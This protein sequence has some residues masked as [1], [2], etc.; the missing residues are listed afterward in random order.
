[1][2]SMRCIR[3]QLSLRP[4]GPMA[5]E[6]EIPSVYADG[7]RGLAQYALTIVQGPV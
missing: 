5:A 1:M 4:C 6:V 3:L 2:F 7:Q